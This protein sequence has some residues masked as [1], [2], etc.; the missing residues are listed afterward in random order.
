MNQFL[1]GLGIVVLLIIGVL[2]YKVSAMLGVA[3]NKAEGPES[4]SNNINGILMLL[5]LIDLSLLN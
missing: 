5:F 2:L 1:V 4:R 3:K